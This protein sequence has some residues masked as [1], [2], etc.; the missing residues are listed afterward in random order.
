MGRIGEYLKFFSIQV[1]TKGKGGKKDVMKKE[2]GDLTCYLPA[3]KKLLSGE[4]LKAMMTV[5]PQ[6]P[7]RTTVSDRKPVATVSDKKAPRKS[8]AA[9]SNKKAPRKSAS[10]EINLMRRVMTKRK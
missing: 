8:A 9:V 3:H 1:P 7:A 6:K 5:G 10:M 4:V 2:R